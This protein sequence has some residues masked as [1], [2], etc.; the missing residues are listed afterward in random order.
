[1]DQALFHLIN[2]QWSSPALDLFMAAISN[3]EIWKPF[4]VVLVLYA[5]FFRGFK[6]R[7][8]VFCCLVALLISSALMVRTL[9]A[10]VDRRRPKQVE[11]AR[12]VELQKARPEFLTLFKRPTI[13]YS[14]EK[15]RKASGPSFPSGHV[16]NNIS[17]AVILT[18]FFRRWGWLYFFV[19]GAIGYS[20]I[21]L[22]AHWPS[23]VLATIFLAAGETLL[24]LALVEMGWRWAG[25]K[26][27]PK[28]FAR[29][30]RIVGDAIS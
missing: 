15:D 24:V 10:A 18:F 21:Y 25:R 13:R 30:P 12:M 11:R 26:W 14:N 9:K 2:E 19:A 28:L 22:A 16:A 27:A 17:I 5:I 4:I 8:L 7:A 3:I 23:D 20:R 29:H 6:G 1:M